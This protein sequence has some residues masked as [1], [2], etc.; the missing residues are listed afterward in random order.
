MKHLIKGCMA[1]TLL[2]KSS[3]RSEFEYFAILK[4]KKKHIK[5]DKNIQF[6]Y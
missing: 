5:G 3:I 6:A 2:A 4:K 1:R